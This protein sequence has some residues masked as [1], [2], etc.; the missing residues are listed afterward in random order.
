MASDSPEGIPYSPPAGFSVSVSGTEAE[1]TPYWHALS[2]EGRV[3]LP[4]ETPPWGGRFGMLV[5]RF[6]ISW[7]VAA[8]AE[9]GT[10]G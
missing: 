10:A 2:A 4:Y 6:G 8:E 7:M 5:D 3:V 9:P 1:V